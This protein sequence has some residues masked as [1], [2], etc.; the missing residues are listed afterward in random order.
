MLTFQLKGGP[1]AAAGLIRTLRLIP[2]ALSLGG[3]TSTVCYPPHVQ[4]DAAN[5]NDP[6]ESGSATI[7]LSVGLEAAD[8]LIADLAQ[9]LATLP[10][11]E[12]F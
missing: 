2:Y 5:G 11:T 7:R 12:T 6:A 3:T 9:A 8:D 10:T 4:P 1:L